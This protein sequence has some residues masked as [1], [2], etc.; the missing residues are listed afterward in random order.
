MNSGEKVRVLRFIFPESA[1]PKWLPRYISASIGFDDYRNNYRS[2]TYWRIYYRDVF[3]GC[4]AGETI[5]YLYIAEVDGVPA[6]RLWFGFSEKH[7]CGNLGNVYTETGYRRLGLMK[8]LLRHC[9]EGFAD[10][11]ALFWACDA[12]PKVIDTYARAGFCQIFGSAYAPM[13][14]LRDKKKNFNDL[15]RQA[16][17]GTYASPK[18]V[19]EGEMRDQFECDKFL[20]YKK[21]VYFAENHR[22]FL[23][24]FIADFRTA[25][26]EKRSDAAKVMILENQAGYCAGYAFAMQCD[27]NN[28]FSQ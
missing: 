16:Y 20:A 4:N 12:A 7:G 10:S 25:Y 9:C 13:A 11:G 1:C 17:F 18:K 3:A 21:E 14:L 27:A 5:D 15:T 2:Q 24:P 6:A 8:L 23:R 19:R 28:Y 26:S 22:T